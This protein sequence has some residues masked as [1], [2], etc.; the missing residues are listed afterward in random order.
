LR[1]GRRFDAVV[2]LFHVI[3]YQVSTTI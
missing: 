2:S 1:L 3:S